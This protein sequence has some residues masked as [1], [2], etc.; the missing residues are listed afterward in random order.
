VSPEVPLDDLLDNDQLP[1]PISGHGENCEAGDGGDC[2][3]AAA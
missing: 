3:S 2:R 1:K